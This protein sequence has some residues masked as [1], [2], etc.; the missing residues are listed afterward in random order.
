M[1]RAV[2]VTQEMTRLAA[3]VLA[4]TKS[5]FVSRSTEAAATDNETPRSSGHGGDDMQESATAAV[6]PERGIGEDGSAR[7][8]QEDELLRF[9]HFDV[10]LS[11]PDHHYLD[12]MLGQVRD[13]LTIP[14]GSLFSQSS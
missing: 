5:Y 10:M 12:N 8:G 9:P 4:K 1:A 13:L 3:N 6:A 7:H 11:P 14:T 2:A